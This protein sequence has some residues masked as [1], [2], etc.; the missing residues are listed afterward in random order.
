[1]KEKYKNHISSEINILKE[2]HHPNIVNYY[3]RIVD[4]ENNKIFIIR[5]FCPGGEINQ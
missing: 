1:M 3:D 5:E 4:K 2:L